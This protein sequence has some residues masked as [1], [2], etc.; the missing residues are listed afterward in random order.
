MRILDLQREAE[1]QRLWASGRPPRVPG[2]LKRV[3][4]SLV[5]A[6]RALLVRVWNLAGLA[7]LR[8]SRRGPIRAAE[9]AEERASE[10][11]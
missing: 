4:P 1:N 9:R 6:A 5:A 2:W 10:V 7:M 11:A 3:L 8:P